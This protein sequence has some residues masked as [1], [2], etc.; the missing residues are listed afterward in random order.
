MAEREDSVPF[1]PTRDGPDHDGSDHGDPDHD[2]SHGLLREGATVGALGATAVALW[3][4]VVDAVAGRPFF[5]PAFLGGIAAGERDLVAV[6]T[7]PGRLWFAALYTPVHYVAFAAVGI[8]AVALVHRA[9]RTPALFGLLL[10]VFLALE[11]AFTGL[12]AA[13]AEGGL[14]T[15]AWYQIAAGN[16]IAVLTMGTFL[17]RRHRST[18]QAWSR[19]FAGG[20]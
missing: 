15:L 4:L 11:V 19:Q 20:E 16:L 8:A 3:F 10:M 9:A 13:L 6:A 14:G 5:T 1:T 2:A 7:G 18:A 17:Y 12:V